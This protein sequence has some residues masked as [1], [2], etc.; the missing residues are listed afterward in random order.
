M[1]PYGGGGPP[2]W[3][4]GGGPCTAG[5]GGGREARGECRHGCAPATRGSGA[6]CPPLHT[7]SHSGAAACGRRAVAPCHRAAAVRQSEGGRLRSPA[8]VA[9]V[10]ASPATAWRALEATAAQQCT[11]TEW[12]WRPHG[13]W[14]HG[15]GAHG[16]GAWEAARARVASARKPH[17]QGAVGVKA[18]VVVHSTQRRLRRRHL[19]AGGMVARRRR[20]ARSGG[21]QRASA[22]SPPTPAPLAHQP[23]SQ[24]Q[25]P[26]GDPCPCRG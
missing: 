26:L 14:A 23:Y 11:R 4:W 13:A 25:S 1:W 7:H 3:P 17:N 5:R 6:G 20:Q 18:G 21:T 10:S 8:R 24:S 9:G 22:P 19:C 12:S 15:P 16:A 2:K